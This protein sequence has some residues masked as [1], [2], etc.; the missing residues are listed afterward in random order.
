MWIR[1]LG[2]EDP[3]EEEMAIHSS[4]PGLKNPMDRGAWRT[5]VHRV[6]ESR[7][8]LKQLSIRACVGCLLYPSLTSGHSGCFYTF[9][10][11]NSATVNTSILVPPQD[12]DFI[13]FR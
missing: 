9:A 12:C 4:I 7:T 13:F 1:S 11:M 2:W 5:S 10:I 3:L 8:G 6:T